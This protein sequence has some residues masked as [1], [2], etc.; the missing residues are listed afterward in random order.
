MSTEAWAIAYQLWNDHCIFGC[1]RSVAN[2][3]VEHCQSR[4]SALR[5]CWGWAENDKTGD[6]T[7]PIADSCNR[8]RSNWTACHL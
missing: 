8:P 3:C 4:P 2:S 7:L 5:A 1:L 6:C